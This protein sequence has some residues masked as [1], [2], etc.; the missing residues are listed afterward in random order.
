MVSGVVYLRATRGHLQGTITS[1]IIMTSTMLITAV[2]F[3]LTGVES[4][5]IRDMGIT[6]PHRE[7]PEMPVNTTAT[8]KSV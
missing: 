8:D 1:N 3:S 2:T 5:D 4:S 6:A 7:G